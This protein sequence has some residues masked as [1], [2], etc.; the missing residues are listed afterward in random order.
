MVEARH[1]QYY[2]LMFSVIW[3]RLQITGKLRKIRESYWQGVYQCIQL[4]SV[5]TMCTGYKKWVAEEGEVKGV[6]RGIK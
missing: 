2:F 4:K 5:T 6:N 1:T 3:G